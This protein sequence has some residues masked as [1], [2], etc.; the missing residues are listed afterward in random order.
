MFRIRAATS[1]YV[2]GQWE[3]QDQLATIDEN[4]VDS[5]VSTVD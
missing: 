3:K 2:S 4:Y 1:D 5:T